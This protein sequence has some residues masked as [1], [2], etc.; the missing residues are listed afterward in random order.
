MTEA[1]T[2]QTEYGLAPAEEGWFVV[3]VPEAAWMTNEYFG[4]ACVIEGEAVAFPDIGYTVHVLRPGQPN[5]LYHREEDQEDFLVLAGEC[6]AIV[7]GEERPMR[8]WDF[9][10]CPPGTE[11]IF[12]GAGTGPCVI[13]MAGGRRHRGSAVYPRSEVAR[14]HGASANSESTPAD[15]PYAPFPKWRPGPPAS[16]DGLPFG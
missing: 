9:L 10:H 16:C 1:R 2:E 7:E 6:I 3:G 12:V 4:D 13:F 14:R 11:H 15:T 8:T 5:G